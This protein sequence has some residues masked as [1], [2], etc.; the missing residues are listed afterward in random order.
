MQNGASKSE[1]TQETVYDVEFIIDKTFRIQGRKLADLEVNPPI[2]TSI[3][4]DHQES[5]DSEDEACSP[6]FH[7]PEAN[8]SAEVSGAVEAA[9]LG[10]VAGLAGASGSADTSGTANSAGLDD[11][12]R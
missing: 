4:P 5:F 3:A 7:P 12:A 8:G 1:S 2:P 6:L 9:G 10:D 11:M